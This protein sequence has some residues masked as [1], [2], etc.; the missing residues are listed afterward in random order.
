[1]KTA[2]IIVAAVA[3]A[4][5]APAAVAAGD[6]QSPANGQQLSCLSYLS[7]FE[8][9][10]PYYAG[11]PRLGDAQSLADKGRNLCKAGDE[12]GARAYLMVALREIG[13]TPKGTAEPP[14]VTI[15]QNADRPQAE[16]APDVY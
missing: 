7:Q 1:M 3:F 8:D 15:I 14:P 13:V 9:A 6:N 10:V 4:L 16:P 5:V 2:S 12:D 11:A